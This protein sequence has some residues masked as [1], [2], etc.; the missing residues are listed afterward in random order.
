MEECVDGATALIIAHPGHELLLHHFLERFRPVVFVLTDGS[1]S[2]GSD[3]LAFSR[4]V[5]AETHAEIGSV[6]GLESDRAWY[7]AILAGDLKLF[8]QAREQ[9]VED[10]AARGVVR[11][12][13]D[14]IELFNPMHDLCAALAAAVAQDLAEITGAP[15]QLFDYAIE[16]GSPPEAAGIEIA[17]DASALRRKTAAALAYAPLAAEVDERLLV[18]ASIQTERV[19]PVEGLELWPERLQRLPHYEDFGRRRV[20]E[21]AY[22]DLITYSGHV[23][24]IA[25]ALGAAGGSGEPY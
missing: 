11:V 3:R 8:H 16:T 24:P 21:G 10:C 2:R 9:I 18:P 25:A 12:V 20:A 14:A 13:A 1:G 5:I 22:R 15:V 4:Q 19:R 17:L 6:F 7:E 23:R